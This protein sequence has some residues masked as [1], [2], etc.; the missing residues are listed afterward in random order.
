MITADAFLL[1]EEALTKLVSSEA[2]RVLSPVWAR[3]D[4][5]VKAGNFNAAQDLINGLSLHSLFG[6]GDDSLLYLTNVAMLFGASRVTQQP[7]TSVVGLGFEQTTSK[8]LVSSFLQQVRV[9]A[10]NQIKSS[11]QRYLGVLKAAHTAF[12][13]SPAPL[14]ITKAEK[15][16]KKR[17]LGSFQSFM[18]DSTRTTFHIASSLHTS[19]VSAYGFTAEA[20]ALGITEYQVSEQLDNRIC[21]VCKIMHGKVFRVADARSLLNTV[22][23]TD[24]PETLKSLQPW[25]SQTKEG[26]DKLK[27]MSSDELVSNGWH[28]PPYHPRCRGL[29]VRVGKAPP[30]SK[31]VNGTANEVYQAGKQ[32]FAQLGFKVSPEKVVQWNKLIGLPPAEVLSRLLGIPEDIFLEKTLAGTGVAK[33][34]GVKKL[35]VG[36]SSVELE[37]EGP[38]AGAS[39]VKQKLSVSDGDLLLKEANLSMDATPSTFK[40]VLVGLY[41]LAKDMGLLSLS[42]KVGGYSAYAYARY[43]FVPSEAEWKVM[44]GEMQT[45]A[46]KLGLYDSLSPAKVALLEAVLKSP[47]PASVYVLSDVSFGELLLSGVS[48]TAHLPLKDQEAIKRFLTYLGGAA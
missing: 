35:S 2:D 40:E 21:P 41:R 34:L 37:T 19:R 7:G 45:S 30:L 11:A 16:P 1:I 42:T 46:T 3:I 22:T 32:D 26:L 29:L 4:S 12:E 17:V 10:L 9:K 36:K 38:L 13:E 39:S 24:D 48:Y 5:E 23:R 47:L 18:K 15:S 28:T 43:G 20:D 14:P 27:S 44:Q 8:Q 33:T 6:D 25:P 31:I